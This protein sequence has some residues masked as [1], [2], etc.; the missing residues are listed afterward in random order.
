MV[1]GMDSFRNHFA[2]YEDQYV[3]IGGTACDLMM[4]KGEAVFRA[5]KDVDLVLLIEALNPSFGTH[6]WKYIKDAGYEHINRD[7]SKS[8]NYRFRHPISKDY[9]EQIE[10]FS[11]FPDERIFPEN[12]RIVPITFDDYIS[13]LSALL[14]DEEY[15]S[16]LNIGKTIVGG[17]S[18]LDI[19]YLI[20][21]KA[22]AWIDLKNRKGNGISIDTA[23]IKKHRNDIFRLSELL[24]PGSK[25]KLPEKVL[26][27][28]HL[29]LEELSHEA[30]S[31]KELGIRGAIEDILS[32]I[33]N[34][35]EGA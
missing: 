12:V 8:Q 25:A 35:Y 3:I 30:I 17:V 13:S 19:P 26:R 1:R 6:F 32:R 20:V 24:T 18:V 16:L 10:L 31:L 5:T 22:K 14:I 11:R 28:F 7:R 33:E 21:F 2:G 23:D 15:Y 34:A 4:T 27:D 9:P 29:S